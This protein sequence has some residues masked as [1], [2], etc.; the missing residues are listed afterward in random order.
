MTPTELEQAINH[1]LEEI[2]RYKSIW[3]AS[4]D[5][6]ARKKMKELQ[7]LQLWHLDQYEMMKKDQS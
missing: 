2:T 4:G 6:T 1:T 7:I 5:E 3:L